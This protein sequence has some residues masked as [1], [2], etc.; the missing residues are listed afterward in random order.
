MNS[1]YVAVASGEARLLLR[2]EDVFAASLDQLKGGSYYTAFLPDSALIAGAHYCDDLVV[3]EDGVPNL[4]PGFSA[5]RVANMTGSVVNVQLCSGMTALII[6]AQPHVV[7]PYQVISAAGD[8]DLVT[9][10]L[11]NSEIKVCALPLK[12]Y[13]LVISG[14]EGHVELEVMRDAF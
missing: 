2:G 10:R 3:A 8:L 1:E 11:G 5:L 12:T 7:T 9:V 4:R 6:E 13:S 14:K